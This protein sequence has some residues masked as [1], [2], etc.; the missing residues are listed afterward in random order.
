[1]GETK[2][3]FGLTDQQKVKLVNIAQTLFDKPT[4]KLEDIEAVTENR[5][6]R[7]YLLFWLGKIIFYKIN[8]AKEME[9]LNEIIMYE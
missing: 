5:F 6:E 9:K 4:I 2:I 3:D 1:M 7:A 8:L